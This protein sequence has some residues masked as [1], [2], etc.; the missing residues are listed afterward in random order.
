MIPTLQ[1]QELP[2][3]SA[4]EA[5]TAFTQAF[6]RLSQAPEQASRAEIRQLLKLMRKARINPEFALLARLGET[7]PTARCE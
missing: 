7:P 6:T 3:Q 4:Q 1:L 2:A 5:R